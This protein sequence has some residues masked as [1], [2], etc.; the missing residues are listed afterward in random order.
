[1]AAQ[2][3]F[4]DNFD[5]RQQDPDEAL[6]IGD[7]SVTKRHQALPGTIKKGAKITISNS[8]INLVELRGYALSSTTS[9]VST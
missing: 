9:I 8:L 3:R 6:T 4:R 7:F 1:M 2:F 5:A